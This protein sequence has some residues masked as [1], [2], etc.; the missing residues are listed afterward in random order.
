[1]PAPDQKQDDG[2]M[3]SAEML[4]QMFKTPIN[5]NLLAYEVA[6]LRREIAALRQ[7]LLPVPGLILTG[8][9][10]LDEFKRLSQ[11]NC[12]VSVSGP[13]DRVERGMPWPKKSP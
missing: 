4:E 7:D 10:A 11:G 2:R 12:A 6:E 1:M 13:F 9:Q 8:R 3:R 5:E